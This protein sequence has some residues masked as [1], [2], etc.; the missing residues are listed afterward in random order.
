MITP[1]ND[2]E[3]RPE[4]YYF[5]DAISDNAVKYIRNYG[6]YTVKTF[7]L[8]TLIQIAIPEQLKAAGVRNTMKQ[9]HAIETFEGDWEKELF[10]Y[11]PEFCSRKTHKVFDDKWKAPENAKLV[12]EARSAAPNKMVVGLD[13][14]A[15]EIQ[16]KGDSKWQRIVLSAND[17]Q[18]ALGEELHGWTGIMELRLMIKETLKEKINF[19]NK[20]LDLGAKW[21]RAKPAFRNLEWLN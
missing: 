19:K 21:T 18:N 3:Y 11:K 20:E 8:S 5:T 10:T 9:S 15:T 6:V 17:F 7:N 4:N 12:L 14:Y 13:K 2:P 16:L 1:E